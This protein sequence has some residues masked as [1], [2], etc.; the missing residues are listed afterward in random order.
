M[1]RTVTGQEVRSWL[2][3]CLRGRAELG[4]YTAMLYMVLEPPKPFEPEARR[5]ASK[6]FVLA[7][8]WLIALVG[9]FMYF[10]LW[11]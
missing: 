4:L 11:S 3:D 8:L 1:A 2:E 6:E 9:L 7:A 5:R 10:N